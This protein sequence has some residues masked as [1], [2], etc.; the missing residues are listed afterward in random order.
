M[1]VALVALWAA[2]FVGC[3]SAP[4]VEPESDYIEMRPLIYDYGTVFDC[5]AEAI[6]EEGLPVQEA[7]RVKG[8]IETNYIP[9]KQDALTGVQIGSRVKAQVVKVGAKDFIVRMTATK[10][11][12]DI[13]RDNQPGEW[14]YVKRDEDLLDKIRRRF[15][16]QVDKRYKAA[17]DKG[18]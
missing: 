8:T 2:P 13:A 15:D 1:A 16:K 6:T 7:D 9:G 14:R 4:V 3:T 10:L 17:S 11:E 18:G 5:V 12:R